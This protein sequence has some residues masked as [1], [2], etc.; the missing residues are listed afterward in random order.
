M[1]ITRLSR[2][3]IGYILVSTIFAC[4]IFPNIFIRILPIPMERPTFYFIASVILITLM[5]MG[6]ISEYLNIK[7]NDSYSA[8][9]V[10]RRR[11]YVL[12][13]I[14]ACVIIYVVIQTFWI[15]KDL[16]THNIFGTPNRVMTATITARSGLP[17]SF[18]VG[19]TITLDNTVEATLPYSD[20]PQVGRQYT[21][22]LLPST[23]IIVDYKQG[24]KGSGTTATTTRQ[25]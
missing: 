25:L 24:D 1:R 12:G 4:I 6:L 10:N 8:R 20:L 7:Y 2:K 14:G 3:T 5:G 16:V 15:G 18:V 21:F 22:T 11:F 19:D 9:T 17:G 23:N 13:P